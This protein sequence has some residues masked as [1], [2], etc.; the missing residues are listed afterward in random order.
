MEEGGV[1]RKLEQPSGA[2]PDLAP[3]AKRPRAKKR[4]PET[5]RPKVI[6]AGEALPKVMIAQEALPKVAVAQERLKPK[7]TE[8]DDAGIQMHIALAE[9]SIARASITRSVLERGE[10]TD[11]N[12]WEYL[13]D[14]RS[15]EIDMEGYLE[16]AWKRKGQKGDDPEVVQ[17]VKAITTLQEI[18]KD[19]REKVESGHVELAARE[20][21]DALEQA[22][23][24]VKDDFDRSR[25]ARKELV[26]GK[27]NAEQRQ[28]YLNYFEE[29]AETLDKELERLNH[30]PDEEQLLY[31]NTASHEATS[32]AMTDLRET[33]H[34]LIKS[35]K[36]SDIAE[37]LVA[38]EDEAMEDA[39][40]IL[41][42][43]SD[44][45]KQLD[46]QIQTSG[47][48][49][50]RR[51]EELIN[52]SKTYIRLEEILKT[53]QTGKRSKESK[54]AME[55]ISQQMEEINDMRA[56]LHVEP[57]GDPDVTSHENINLQLRRRRN[58]LRKQL[59]ELEVKEKALNLKIKD[60]YGKS[61]EKI[62]A[63]GGL[64]VGSNI[65][66]AMKS[67]VGKPDDF[68]EWRRLEKQ[69]GEIRGEMETLAKEGWAQGKAGAGRVDEDV[70]AARATQRVDTKDYYEDYGI[71]PS[72]TE[73]EFFQ[74]SLGVDD[75][76][77]DV[78]GLEETE[79]KT[80]KNVKDNSN[81][82]GHLRRLIYPQRTESKRPNESVDVDLSEVDEYDTN[83]LEAAKKYKIKNAE[84][85][86]RN[87]AEYS[88]MN[89]LSF[90][91]KEYIEL[92]TEVAKSKSR[93]GNKKNPIRFI[94]KLWKAG[95]QDM[96]LRMKTE[97][98]EH[99]IDPK[100]GLAFTKESKRARRERRVR[101]SVRPKKAA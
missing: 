75:V 95:D 65:A 8:A 43:T 62:V 37:R 74:H 18:L 81:P 31:D 80:A 32:Q 53:L 89:P 12:A 41:N 55:R 2:P 16:E 56:R 36:A 61:P 82:Y 14:L 83:F 30:L 4:R 23:G 10:L 60:T 47:I 50:E 20:Y 6:I 90:S 5:E 67:L 25:N 49:D 78:K 21:S 33:I 97:L 68:E 93:Q 46:L 27:L 87:I 100:T 99:G 79:L 98:K 57:K 66:R 3:E 34:E 45:L 54:P 51:E 52:L 9:A 69:A 58:A 15:R 84:T 42:S 1:A 13:H 38:K 22:L 29:R 70:A 88:A 72:T 94:V 40:T 48:P 96:L 24:R 7:E 26:S 19:V 85:L 92:L 91:A 101:E 86:L 11:E 77:V 76:D 17:L 35:E 73:E 64:N 28:R 59:A 39:E 71:T 63:Q 44:L